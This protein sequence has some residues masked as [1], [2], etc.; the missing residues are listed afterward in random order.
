MGAGREE[1]ADALFP[2][3]NATS[4]I[5]VQALA[6]SAR[7]RTSSEWADVGKE[8]GEELME[9][10]RRCTDSYVRTKPKAVR[11]GKLIQKAKYV[12]WETVRASEG[13][14]ELA[15]LVAESFMATEAPAPRTRTTTHQNP[16][17]RKLLLERE[18]RV[19]RSFERRR[20][21]S[22]VASLRGQFRVVRCCHLACGEG[23]DHLASRSHSS[24]QR[25][26][27]YAVPPRGLERLHSRPRPG[28]GKHGEDVADGRML[29]ASGS[30][31]C[32]FLL[33]F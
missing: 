11:S 24:V 33:A 32:V 1:E 12:G 26:R 6:A 30:G 20:R 14:A 19:P 23:A 10:R 18:G 16:R 25:S 9:R 17:Q 5:R 2:R 21:A 3:S 15:L 31:A 4:S 28:W 7:R 13:G 8:R 29:V 22:S 27:A